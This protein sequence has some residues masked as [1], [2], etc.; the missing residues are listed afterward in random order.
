MKKLS[1]V[2]LPLLLHSVLALYSIPLAK[3]SN[4]DEAETYQFNILRKHHEN[5]RKSLYSNEPQSSR[6][7]SEELNSSRLSSAFYGTISVGTPPQQ[8]TVLFD[9]GSSN[10]WLPSKKCGSQCGRLR[11]Y[12]SSRSK[13]YK[14]K[15]GK[16]IN[17]YGSGK[18]SGSLC[19]D[20][21]D[22]AGL[23]VKGVTFTEITREIGVGKFGF[24]GLIGLGFEELA[25]GDVPTFFDYVVHQR[26]L[27]DYSFSF[28]FGQEESALVLGGVDPKYAKSE[29]I[30]AP[31]VFNYGFWAMEVESVLV[32]NVLLEIPGEKF[33]ATVDTGTSVTIFPSYLMEVIYKT[34]GLE[35]QDLYLSEVV[36]MLP[37]IGFRLNNGIVFVSPKD[38]MVCAESVCTPGFLLGKDNVLTGPNNILLG[39]SFLKA[40]YTHF[41]HANDRVGFATAV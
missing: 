7:F 26:L 3:N 39:L 12:D 32:G 34:L 30:Y 22:V 9:T 11:R 8:F 17:H 18:V 6:N 37:T 29:F 4:S 5:N 36:E 1:I 16:V 15:H 20:N 19:I 14:S 13:S 27:D 35:D 21:V 31:L 41:D 25:S 33:V 2:F 24:D 10:F 28:Y 38:Y 23:K 40:F